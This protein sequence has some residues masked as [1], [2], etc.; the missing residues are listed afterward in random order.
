M[1]PKIKCEQEIYELM[2]ED[3]TIWRTRVY[4]IGK[5]FFI[6]DDY[7]AYNEYFVEFK[8]SDYNKRWFTNVNKAVAYL[9][10]CYR[11]QLKEKRI[12]KKTLYFENGKEIVCRYE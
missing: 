8:F 6:T 7:Y 11:Q 2:A 4:A 1:I 9:K 3:L 5:D 12:D 10:K